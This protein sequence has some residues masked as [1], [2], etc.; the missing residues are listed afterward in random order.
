MS[1]NVCWSSYKSVNE[2]GKSQEHAKTRRTKG[3]SE[4]WTKGSAKGF[5]GIFWSILRVTMH[6][7]KHKEH[8]LG[9]QEF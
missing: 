1:M 6:S 3:V 5:P 9:P 2:S 4:N 8:L 7:E